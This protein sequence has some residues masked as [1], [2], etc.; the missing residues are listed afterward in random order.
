[1]DRSIITASHAFFDE[2]LAPIL[3]EKFPAETARTAFGIF[4]Y[5]SEVLD[6][7]DA[8]SSDHHWGLRVNAL[9]PDTLLKERGAEL[10]RVVEA[11]LPES[12]GGHALRTGYAGTKALSL[13]SLEGFL[14]QTIGLNHPPQTPAEWLGIPE[15]DIIHVING[16]IWHDDSGRFSAIRATLNGY[17][18][19]PVRLRRIAH[20]CRYFSGMGTYALQRAIL[21]DNEHYAAIAFGKA[22]RWGVQ[23][24]FLLEKHY[25]PYDKWTLAWLDRLPRLGQ[26]V[27]GLVDEAVRLTTTWTRKL[28]LLNALADLLDQTMVADGIIRPHSAFTAS[29]TSGYRLTEHAYA[30]IIQ[31]LPREIQT[32]VPVWDQIYL[33]RMHSGYVA[34]LEMSEWDALLNLKPQ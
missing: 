27:R 30:E 14:N 4:G 6:L 1:M 20:W 17:Y 28:E 18:P 29:P 22:I 8:Y 12:Y 9:M 24:A 31:G 25:C 15:E 11:H 34:G 23:L 33:E 21:R 2:V 19:E 26:P 10:M 7:D 32:I 5:G 3:W 16:E 13:N